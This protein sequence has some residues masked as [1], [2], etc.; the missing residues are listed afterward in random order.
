VPR[1]LAAAHPWI[2]EDS[3]QANARRVLPAIA[4]EYFAAGRKIISSRPDPAEL[5]PFR[6]KTKQVRYTL[7]GFRGLYGDS[8]SVLLEKLKPLQDALGEVND[9]V[10]TRGEFDLGKRFDAFLQRRAR[11]KAKDFFKAWKKEFDAPGEEQKWVTGLRSLP[12]SRP[13]R[14]AQ[15]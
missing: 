15:N 9:A 12:E 2:A 14:S 6:L 7:E 4:R 1:R 11:A 10:A 3:V 5:H 8:V 13:D